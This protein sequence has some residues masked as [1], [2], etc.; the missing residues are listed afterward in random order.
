MRK[1]SLSHS[2][3]TEQDAGNSR[4][5]CT[6]SQV[7]RLKMS[8]PPQETVRGQER[9]WGREGGVSEW[10]NHKGGNLTEQSVKGCVC[11]N[12]IEKQN[13]RL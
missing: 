12:V 9:D 11:Q 13:L 3:S 2:W 7:W 1:S 6:D 5:D 10:R 8:A 4:K